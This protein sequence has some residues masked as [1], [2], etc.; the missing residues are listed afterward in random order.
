MEGSVLQRASFDK[1]TTAAIKG[2]A[3]VMMFIHHFFAYPE[4][5]V[6]GVA[7][8]QLAEY[9]GFFRY[10][11]KICVS[12]FAFLTGFFYA[13]SGRRT[14]RYS[15]RKMT[16]LLVSYWAVYIPV[17]LFALATGY[18]GLTPFGFAEGILGR[19]KSVMTFCWY[20]SFYC[21]TMAL[22]PL[23]TGT[24]G[25]A[26]LREGV[27][28][29]IIPLA[30]SIVLTSL[31]GSN[32]IKAMVE[33]IRLWFPCVAAGYLC[34]KYGVFD[35]LE[36]KL[37]ERSGLVR[38]L[39]YAACVVAPCACRYFINDVTL[40]S[41]HIL[42]RE[43]QIGFTMDAVYAPVFVYGLSMLLQRIEKSRMFAV[44]GRIGNQSLLMWF[45]HCVFFNVS[46][47]LT[48]RILYA[49]KHPVLVVLFGLALCYAAALAISPIVASLIRLKNRL[50]EGRRMAA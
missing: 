40:G 12:V 49:P 28:L 27:I 26:P 36:G 32:T 30:A 11:M 39:A 33:D 29:V 42:G 2:T 43:M 20:V 44:L 18:R 5:Y 8:P 46:N 23:L 25:R 16:D 15:L 34:G 19:N 4:W 41:V 13:Y 9:I 50:L 21:I 38:A 7:Y 45:I 10:S 48:Q 1:K 47:E 14:L 3:L 35:A 17:L 24:K 31:I 6:S 22:L 37:R